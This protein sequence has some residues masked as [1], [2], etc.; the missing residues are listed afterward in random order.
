MHDTMDDDALVAGE[1]LERI[2]RQWRES[3]PPIG[4]QAAAAIAARARLQGGTDRTARPTLPWRPVAVAA[5]AAVVAITAVQLARR[6]A[7]PAPVVASAPAATP[8]TVRADAD[9]VFAPAVGARATEAITAAARP[10][11]LVLDVPEAARVHAVGDF[12]QW[13]REATPL[14]RDPV[15]GRWTVMLQLVPGRY[16]Y[17]F[18]VDGRRWVADPAHETVRD[19]D[20]GQPTSELL[21]EQRP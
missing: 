1:P 16:R 2:V 12:N 6:D 5:A 9:L 10:V 4:P 21:V 13:S 15:T 19:A 18:L 7:A 3:A 14:V 17:A 20:F 11:R 8:A